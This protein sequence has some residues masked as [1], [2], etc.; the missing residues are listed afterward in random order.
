MRFAFGFLIAAF[1]FLPS[2]AHPE[3]TEHVLSN[4]LKVIIAED[5]KSPVSVFQIWY[6]VGGRDEV[7]GTTGISHLLEHMMFKGTGR[8]G[9]KEFSKIIKKNG[10]TDN[11]FTSKDSTAYFQIISSDRLRIPI[12]LEADR[13]KNLLMEENETRSERLVVIEERRLRY[14]DDPRS[15]LFEEVLAAAF[16]VHPYGRPVIGWMSDIENITR[17]DLLAH[18]KRYYSPENAVIVAAGDVAP[19]EALKKIEEHFLEIPPGPGIKRLSFEEPPQRGQR[20]VYLRREAELPYMIAVYR[21]PGIPHPD[22]YALEVLGMVLSGGKSARLYDSLV[23]EKGLAIS[24]DAQYDG[25]SIDPFLFMVDAVPRPGVDVRE[26]EEAVYAEIERL[27][28]GPPSGFE[29][30]KAKNQIEADFIMG[31]DSVYRQAMIL[32]RFEMLGSWRLKDEYLKGILAV[33]A[34]DVSRAAQKY[35]NEDNRTAGVLVPLKEGEK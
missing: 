6:R 23:R 11:A 5:H 30:M 27:K 26:L 8:F 15:S 34:E 10:G 4:G 25:L 24:A 35:L 20:R 22:G 13:M 12:E 33:T 9:S 16:K 29:L 32:G 7:S 3:V 18:Y 31:Q 28:T 17:E 21:T 2:R 14:E 1:L 19:Q